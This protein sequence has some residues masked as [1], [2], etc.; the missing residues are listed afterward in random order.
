[1]AT[2]SS[3]VTSRDKGMINLYLG[4]SGECLWVACSIAALSNIRQKS[5]HRWI[6]AKSISRVNSLLCPTEFMDLLPPT[7]YPPTYPPTSLI[8]CCSCLLAAINSLNVSVVI[9]GSASLLRKS[10]QSIFLF[11]HTLLS[12]LL[13]SAISILPS[14]FI[15]PQLN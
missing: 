9:T 15:I 1:M 3:G 4:D 13:P 8:R 6:W 2:Y 7:R 11:F 5:S 10:D 14:K 12:A